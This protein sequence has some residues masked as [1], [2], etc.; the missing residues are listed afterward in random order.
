M[1]FVTDIIEYL[2]CPVRLYLKKIKNI[3]IENK[4]L[5]RGKIL[6]R[7]FELFDSFE[8]EYLNDLE[9]PIELERFTKDYIIMANRGLVRAILEFNAPQT[10]ILELKDIIHREA[11]FRA[12]YVWSFIEKYGEQFY[13]KINPIIKSEILLKY[14]DL[15]GR[16]DRL[17]KYKSGRLIPIEIKTGTY[18]EYHK[19]QLAGYAILLEKNYNTK[20]DVG[21]L[22]YT[23]TDRYIEVELDPYKELFLEL[24]EKVKL[25]LDSPRMIANK[26]YCQYCDYKYFCPVYNNKKLEFFNNTDKNLNG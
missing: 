12:N 18:K 4:R 23:K 16:I 7:A 2:I 15:V 13:N 10:Y 1:I 21:L 19:I 17:E 5:L 20:I 11:K 22:Y 14:N 8:K 24:Y 26:K 9:L 3:K 6:H 25:F